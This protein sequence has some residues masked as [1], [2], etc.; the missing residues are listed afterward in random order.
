MG[1]RIRKAKVWE[2]MDCNKANHRKVGLIMHNCFLGKQMPS[3]QTFPPPSSPLALSLAVMSYVIEYSFSSSRSAILA[4]SPPSFL[5][6]PSL[7]S[8]SRAEKSLTL[9]KHHSATTN[10]SVCYQHYLHHKSKIPYQQLWRKTTSSQNKDI[11]S[12]WMLD[13]LIPELKWTTHDLEYTTR[14]KIKTIMIHF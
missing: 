12:D 5:C 4:V 6:T 3:L 14:I 8:G 2:L 9:C 13:F 10:T 1:E 11:Q 7:F